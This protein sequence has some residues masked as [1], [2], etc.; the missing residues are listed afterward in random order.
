MSRATKTPII[1]TSRTRNET[2]YSLIR[3]LI[4]LNEARIE[5]HDRVVVRT[6]STSDRPSIPSLN[7]M[8]NSGIQSASTTYW[9]SPLR[10]GVPE[11]PTT[12]SSEKT[13]VRR[14]APSARGRA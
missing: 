7:W 1:P 9:N 11:K 3:S 6:T 10:S 4:G 12:R 13:Q 5:I 14:A 2:M 8:P